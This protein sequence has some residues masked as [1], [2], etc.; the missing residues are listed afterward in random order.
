MAAVH[1]V[2]AVGFGEPV[3]PEEEAW[4]CRGGGGRREVIFQIGYQI[5]GE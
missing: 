1:M 2:V 5:G 3:G 4:K